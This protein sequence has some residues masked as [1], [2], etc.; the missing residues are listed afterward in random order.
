[1]KRIHIALWLLL[2]GTTGA[3]L[4]LDGLW[5][6]PWGWFSLRGPIVQY[7]GVLAVVAMAAAMLLAMRLRWLED[8]LDGL[9]KMYRL[10][11]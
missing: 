1:M 11:K 3:F 7:T 10:H 2:A 8:R 5:P 6:R 9:D 4:L